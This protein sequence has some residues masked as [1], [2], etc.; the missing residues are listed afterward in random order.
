MNNKLEN[1]NQKLITQITDLKNDFISNQ[2]KDDEIKLMNSMNNELEN[3]KQKLIT[4][5]LLKKIQDLENQ[6]QNDY[7][8]KN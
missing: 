4:D 3:E 8:P 1:E 5:E 6:I 7:I 2:K